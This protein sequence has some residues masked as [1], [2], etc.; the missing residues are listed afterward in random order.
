MKGKEREEKERGESRF[1]ALSEC[2]F[3]NQSNSTFQPLVGGERKKREGKGKKRGRRKELV[4]S[5]QF[6]FAS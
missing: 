6:L 3:V 2:K 5:S 4:L 1:A